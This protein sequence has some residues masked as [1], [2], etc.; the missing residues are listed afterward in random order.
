MFRAVWYAG[1]N[2][3]IP[4]GIPDSNPHRITGTKCRIN[5]VVSPDVGHIVGRNMWRLINILRINILRK[6]C[7]PSWVYLQDNITK[8]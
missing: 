3:N 4:P 7:A 2:E 1:W 8:F 6:N 5:T